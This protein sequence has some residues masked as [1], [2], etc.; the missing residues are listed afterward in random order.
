MARGKIARIFTAE[1]KKGHTVVDAAYLRESI[2]DPPAKTV[3]SH[4]RGEYAM[5]SYAGALADSQ[6]ESII[7]FIKTLK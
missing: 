1:K 7:L 6:I 5:P 4:E 3:A 2:T